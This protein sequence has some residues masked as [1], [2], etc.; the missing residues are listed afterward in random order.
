MDDKYPSTNVWNWSH[1]SQTSHPGNK[2]AD[3][4]SGSEV[5][6]QKNK[7]KNKVLWFMSQTTTQNDNIL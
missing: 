3:K 1:P 4:K 5:H 6:I 2:L 7:N